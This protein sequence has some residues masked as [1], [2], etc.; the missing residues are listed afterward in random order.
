[1][2]NLLLETLRDSKDD[3]LNFLYNRMRSEEVEK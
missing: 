2:S 1:M 3:F